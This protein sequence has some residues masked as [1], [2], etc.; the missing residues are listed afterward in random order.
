VEDAI[1]SSGMAFT[2]LRPNLYM[3]GLLGFRQLITTEG[4]FFAS[5]GDASVSVVDVRDIA[6][7]AAAVLTEPGHEGRTYDITGPQ[8]LTH[9]Q[10]ASVL[11]TVSGRPV[12]YVDLSEDAMREGLLRF[13]FP[14][15]QADGLIED[16]AH[17]RRGE[18]SSVSTAVQDVTG[19]PPRSF[20]QFVHDYWQPFPK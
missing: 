6:A 5:V 11:T 9:A 4:R 12:L 14:E 2:H 20:G 18:A 17:Y 8:S 15:W 16:Y 10:M 13:G 3:Q 19:Q 7:I 1:A